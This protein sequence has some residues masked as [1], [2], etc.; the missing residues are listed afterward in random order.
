MKGKYLRR[1]GGLIF[2]M[3]MIA[4][5]AFV[6]P[7]TAEAQGRRRIVI[8]RPYPYR[9]YSPFGFRRW[10]YNPWGYDPWAY[11]SY[12]SHYIFDNGEEAANQG[13]KDGFKTGKDDGKKNKSFS[14]ER[15][16]YFKEAGFGNF[17]E[18]Y[19]SS[20]SRGYNEGFRVGSSHAG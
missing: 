17:A 10:G 4:G 1:L 11:Q 19:R 7:S 6:S 18:I 5:V 16:H 14:F 8:V 9:Y 2:A 3:L 12:Y 13:Y 15:S 20:F